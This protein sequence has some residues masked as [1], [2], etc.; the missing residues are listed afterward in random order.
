[1][2]IKSD[3]IILDIDGTIWNTTHV[4]TVAWNGAIDESGFAAQKVTSEALQKEF[5]KPMNVIADDLW[6]NLTQEQKNVL[7]EKC[8]EHEQVALKANQ[9]DISYPAVREGIKELA[10][11]FNIYIVSNCQSG[12]IELTMEKNGIQSFIRDHECYGN[13]K[14]G[15]ADN[16][17][18][19]VERNSLKAPVYVGDTQGDAD[20]C[21]EAGVKFIWASYGFGSVDSCAAKISRFDEL[22]DLLQNLD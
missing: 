7:M 10:K 15:K 2:R 13:T 21:R 3:G 5:G 22:L 12:Y 6:P 11:R 18:F 14:K 17:R 19:L 20:A 8:C 9:K 4:I 1:M 16:L